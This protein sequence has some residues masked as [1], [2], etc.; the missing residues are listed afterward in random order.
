MGGIL[1]KWQDR[2]SIS[3]EAFHTLWGVISVIEQRSELERRTDYHQQPD[4]SGGHLAFEES[5][6]KQQ[7]QLQLRK[8][9]FVTSNLI[10]DGFV[11]QADMMESLTVESP[12]I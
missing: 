7:F 11:Y 9:K 10:E 4:L 1:R 6:S 12:F 3:E 2:Y 8:E 5:A